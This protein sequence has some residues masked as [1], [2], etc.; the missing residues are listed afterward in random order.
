MPSVII[1]AHNEEAVIARGLDALLDGLGAD[2]EVVVV[3]NGCSDRTVEVASRYAPRVQVGETPVASKV[4]A[5]NLGDEIATTFP[6]IYLDADVTLPGRAAIAIADV[7]ED[8]SGPL[9]AGP[10]RSLDLSAS[11]WTVRADFDIWNQIPDLQDEFVGS[12]AYAMSAAGRARFDRFP[13]LV[14]DDLFVCRLFGPEERT[15]VED[16]VS[17]V[18]PPADLNRLLGVQAR[19]RA[20]NLQL[21]ERAGSRRPSSMGRPLL[22]LARQPRNWAPIGVFVYVSVVSRGRG[23]W[24]AWYGDPTIWDRDESSRQLAARADPDDQP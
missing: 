22:R 9:A 6:R 19:R 8:P 2:W 24:R 11:P 14:S 10:R 12:G 15:T 1:P 5:M 23:K 4:A 18:Y 20:G 7:L 16:A 3:G 17:V 21:P 13:D